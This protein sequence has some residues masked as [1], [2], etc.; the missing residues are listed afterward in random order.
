MGEKSSGEVQVPGNSP[1][2]WR[3][4]SICPGTLGAA[5]GEAALAGLFEGGLLCLKGC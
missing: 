4:W 1:V 5:A 2:L 3:V